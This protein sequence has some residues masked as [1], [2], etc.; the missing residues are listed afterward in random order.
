MS[1]TTSPILIYSRQT[2]G[3]RQI[4]CNVLANYFLERGCPVV[5]MVGLESLEPTA[6]RPP[7][8]E[9]LRTHPRVQIVY[10]HID[11]D[12]GNPAREIATIAQIQQEHSIGG[13]FFADGDHVRI[14]LNKLQAAGGRPRLTGQLWMLMLRHMSLTPALAHEPQLSPM[15]SIR[16]KLRGLLDDITFFHRY[17]PQIGTPVLS[18]TLDPR[19]VQLIRRPDVVWMPDIYRQFGADP[20][21]LAQ[22]ALLAELQGFVT[23]HTS[24]E[25]VLYFGTN[26]DRRGYDWLL[27]AVHADP[28]LVFLHTG[29]LSETKAMSAEARTLRH[30]LRAQGRLFESQTFITDDRIVDLAFS[31]T[32]YVLLPY[33]GHYGSSGVSIQSASYG[34]PILVPHDGLMGYWVRRTGCGLTFRSGDRQAF[35]KG[36]QQLRQ[37][38]RTY[39]PATRTY[40]D[41][42]S[43]QRLYQTLDAH[44]PTLSAPIA[45]RQIALE[46][47]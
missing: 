45:P 25:I 1:R 15:R 44:M 11:A 46:R 17:L 19:F 30:N 41:Y 43:K 47:R 10:R 8:I 24:R 4:Y 16:R 40:V 12:L 9:I 27:Q 39:V 26:Q 6:T 42:F 35:L 2:I 23:R 29:K 22:D 13:T 3:H 7:F 5:V 38:W 20:S 36:F 33:I 28:G 21:A 37:D 18:F 32:N 34:K 31:S 14:S